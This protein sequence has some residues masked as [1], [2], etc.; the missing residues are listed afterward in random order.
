MTVVSPARP[1]AGRPAAAW[2]GLPAAQSMPPAIWA[3]PSRGSV[4][5][6]SI[7]LLRSATTLAESLPL[8]GIFNSPS[9]LIALMIKLSA[10]LP[11]TSAGPVSPPLSVA[12]RVSS[13]RPPDCFFSPWQERH[14]STR[15]GRI[16]VSKNSVFGSAARPVTANKPTQRMLNRGF[17][18]RIASV[19]EVRVRREKNVRPTGGRACF[20][21][22]T[23][24]SVSMTIGRATAS[25][26]RRFGE[27]DHPTT[28]TGRQNAPVWP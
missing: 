11:A 10:G 1:K 7:H 2:P 20:M 17:M 9:C 18:G 27:S 16:L 26:T 22:T 23:G 8:G 25:S 13:R 28:K 5:P 3:A 4:A 15:T 6:V 21:L 19:G 14:C 24:G 12:C